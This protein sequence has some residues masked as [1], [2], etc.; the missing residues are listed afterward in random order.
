[1]RS[2]LLQVVLGLAGCAALGMAA[3]PTWAQEM[4]GWAAPADYADPV[5]Y[6]DPIPP[7]DTG[8]GLPGDPPPVPV[9]GGLSGLMLAGAV[10]AALRLRRDEP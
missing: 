8:P 2:I 5:P 9:G 1:M 7:R 4:P 6:D 3:L 10:Y